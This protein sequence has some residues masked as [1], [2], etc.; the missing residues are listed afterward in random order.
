[1]KRIKVRVTLTEEMLGM[2]ASPE[3]HEKYIASKAP[4]AASTAEE[5]EALGVDEVIE[6]KRTIFPREQNVPIL[7]DY[8]VKGAFK[9]M[10]GML[11]RVAGTH[12]A[13]LTSFKKVIDGMIFVEPR[14]IPLNIGEGKTGN[15]QRPLRAD[16]AQGP[17]VALADSETVPV[18]TMFE[19]EVILMEPP[20]KNGKPTLEALL[21]EWLDYGVY[22]GFGQWRNSGK[23]KFT[24][25]IIQ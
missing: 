20:K 17:R 23:G 5:V 18:G 4:D 7:W 9:D 8:Q 3:V 6:N 19:F 14:K 16:T 22:R 1:M 10:C 13:K 15:C 11:R 25:E 24:Y 2:S 12:S 21:I